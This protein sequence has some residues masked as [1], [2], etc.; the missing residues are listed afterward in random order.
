MLILLGLCRTC[1]ETT[2]LLFRDAAQ[3]S[4]EL[5]DVDRIVNATHSLQSFPT[6]FSKV[7]VNH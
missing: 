6:L 4:K 7:L 5:V 2:L 1:S 3:I